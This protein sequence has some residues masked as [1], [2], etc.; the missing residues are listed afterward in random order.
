MRRIRSGRK[1]KRP[2][3]MQKRTIRGDV[4]AGHWAAGH[5]AKEFIPSSPVT[6]NC[7]LSTPE[8]LQRGAGGLRASRGRVREG[9]RRSNR[10]HK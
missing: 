9:A 5:S 1:P 6:G 10:Q 8:S 2:K 7:Y 3:R 4:S